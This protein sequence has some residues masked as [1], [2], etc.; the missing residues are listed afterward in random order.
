MEPL[1]AIVIGGGQAGL[2]VSRRL[3][4]MGVDHVV[5]ERERIGET[6]RQRWDSFCLV[7]PNWSVQLPGHPYDGNDPDGFMP[8]DE[9]VEYLERYAAAAKL[10]VREGVNVISLDSASGDGFRVRTDL[11][12]LHAKNVVLA[13]GAYQRAFRPAGATALPKDLLQIDIGGFRNADALP[14]GGVLIVGSGQ[15]GCQIAEELHEAGRDVVVATLVMPT[16]NRMVSPTATL[17]TRVAPLDVAVPSSVAVVRFWTWMVQ[18]RAAAFAELVTATRPNTIIDASNRW[19][20]L[21]VF[22][23]R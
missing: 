8:R 11:E 3:V 14:A 23:L 16:V 15:S 10:P 22:L 17:T 18:S 12:T 13:T 20:T 5:L 2:T 1:E 6:W 9:L 19:R 21:I 7:T 4:E